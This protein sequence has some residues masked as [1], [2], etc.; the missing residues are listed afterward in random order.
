MLNASESHTH[1][2]C[3]KYALGLCHTIWQL[4]TRCS[5]T[6]LN[7]QSLERSRVS[8]GAWLR[9]L[10]F[11]NQVGLFFMLPLNQE[12][13]LKGAVACYHMKSKM[14]LNFVFF[15]CVCLVFL[16]KVFRL[17]RDIVDHFGAYICCRKSTCLFTDAQS[18]NNHTESLF[19]SL[20]GTL[21][22]FF[23]LASFYTI[24]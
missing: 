9:K 13:S 24:I 15:V 23:L 17:Y 1:Y 12:T 8:T 11:K 2:P 4:V 19:K 10:F 16:S 22:L 6:H 20:L 7:D 5:Q 14:W 3:S 21:A 18:W